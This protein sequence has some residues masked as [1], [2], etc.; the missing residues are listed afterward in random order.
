MK[1]ASSKR[2]V[3][4]VREMRSEYDFAKGIR[5]KHAAR[6]AAGTNVVILDP[7][8]AELFPTSASV[9]DALRLLAKLAQRSAR[10]GRKVGKRA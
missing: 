9:N 2:S 5:G 1:Q 8:V 7:D 4:A 6:Y 3:D 10:K